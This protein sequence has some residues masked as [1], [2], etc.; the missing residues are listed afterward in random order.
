MKY[1]QKLIHTATVWKNSV[2]DNYGGFTFDAPVTVD[3]R[4]EGKSELFIDKT[5]REAVSK[6]VIWLDVD[7]G[8]EEG[9]MIAYGDQT[10]YTDPY[11][12]ATAWTLKNVSST[13]NL[14]GTQTAVT[15]YI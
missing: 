8:I 9:D 12:C 3:C 7:D 10:T 14:R 2:S 5:G 4:W 13:D 11:D 6:A 15:G 1:R